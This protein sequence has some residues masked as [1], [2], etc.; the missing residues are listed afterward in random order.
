MICACLLAQSCLTLFDPIDCGPPSSFVDG[1]SPGK[2]TGV[3][4]PCPPPGDLPNQ[5][6]N[7]VLPHCR[8]ILYP[9]SHQRSPTKVIEPNWSSSLLTS[10]MLAKEIVNI[11]TSLV[12]QWLRFLAPNAGGTRVHSLVGELDP[13]CSN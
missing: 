9:L 12:V 11:G 8:Q 7:P 4:S 1:N 3:G 13:T 2:N 6:S 5:G 10:L